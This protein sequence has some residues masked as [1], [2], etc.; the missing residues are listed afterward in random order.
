MLSSA[1]LATPSFVAAGLP[2]GQADSF[3]LAGRRVVAGARELV[4]GPLLAVLG[5]SRGRGSAALPGDEGDVVLGSRVLP[6]SRPPARQNGVVGA[7]A[8]VF[9]RR[10]RWVVTILVLLMLASTVYFRMVAGLEWSLA[11]YAAV[12]ASTLTGIGDI[13][14]MS[15]AARFGALAIQLFGLVLSS[16]ITAVIVDALLS[17]RLAAL[18]GGVRGKPTHH[19]VVCGLGRIGRAVALDLKQRGMPVIAIERTETTTGV[20]QARQAGIPVIVAEASDAQVLEQAGV[21]RAD[22][23]MALTDNDAANLEIALTARHVRPDVRLVIRLFDQGLAERVERRLGL[24]QT[25][26]VS[27]VA[28]PAFAAAVLGHRVDRVVSVGRQVLVLTEVEVARVPGGDRALVGQLE[29]PHQ[30]RVLAHRR[31]SEQW[32]WTVPANTSVRPGDLVAVAATRS[33][34][35][36]LNRLVA[37]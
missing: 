26:S 18:A 10:L 28:A 9:D 36:G 31:Q 24:G 12:T 25:R 23:V 37:R 3:D 15:P 27:M 30:V 19:V 8:R 6:V 29:A 17:A 20:S 7:V 11:F 34:L 32:S 16:G 22:T 14:E 1:E 35:A 33:G 21:S 13:G 4:G 2:G 5:N